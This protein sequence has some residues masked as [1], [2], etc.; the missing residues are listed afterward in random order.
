MTV[1]LDFAVLDELTTVEARAFY[2]ITDKLRSCGVTKKFRYPQIVVVGR[3]SDGKSSVLEAISHMR[4]PV[5]GDLCTRFTTDLVLQRRRETCVDVDI[6]FADSSK[7]SQHFKRTGFCPDDLP[8]IIEEAQKFMG[9]S[10]TDETFSNDLL[11]LKIDHPDTCPLRLVDVPGIDTVDQSSRSKEILDHLHLAEFYM[12]ME[13]SILLVIISASSDIA[14]HAALRKARE[15]DPRGERTM[16]IITKPDVAQEFIDERRYTQLAKSQESEQ[17]LKLG[18]H[19]LRNRAG[20]GEDGL[21]GRDAIEARFFQEDAWSCISPNDCGIA[22]LRQKLSKALWAGV[23]NNLQSV[24]DSIQGR[25]RDTQ[26]ELQTLGRPRSTIEDMRSFLLNVAGEFQRLA[27]D[28][29]RRT[30]SD[31]FFGT[32]DP[33][34][35]HKLRAQLSNFNSAFDHVLIGKENKEP[36]TEFLAG[37]LERYPYD[38]PEPIEAADLK[39]WLKEQDA[40]NQ[41]F[42]GCLNKEFIIHLFQKKAARWED[43]AALHIRQ[44]TLVT[45][46]F[47]DR[48][49]QHTIAN[50]TTLELILRNCVDPFFVQKEKLLAEKLDELLRPYTRGYAMPLDSDFRRAMSRGAQPNP[51]MADGGELGTSKVIDTVGWY[52][53]MSRRTFADNVMNLALEGCLIYDIPE[54]LTPMTVHSM[55]QERL[56]ELAS[57]SDDVKSRRQKLQEDVKILQEGLKLC[58]QYRPRGITTI[59]SALP[60]PRPGPELLEPQ[61]AIEVVPKNEQ[62]VPSNSQ[63]LLSTAKKTPSASLAPTSITA[64]A[65][66]GATKSSG[67][68]ARALLTPVPTP[69]ALPSTTS[70]PPAAANSSTLFVKSIN[71]PTV[72]PSALAPGSLFGGPSSETSSPWEAQSN[73]SHLN[74]VVSSSSTGTGLFGSFHSRNPS[75][76]SSFSFLAKK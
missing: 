46:A 36:A 47:V 31:P 25:L 3:S 19:I 15:Y 2:A 39:E 29:I 67:V 14:D 56:I 74:S 50:S 61:L 40:S 27:R 72:I 21:E 64:A 35:E 58:R 70:V 43:V 52:Y 9:V 30:Y 17:K 57:E 7:P 38:L 18:W 23:K 28:G 11:R 66:S 60:R 73:S 26:Q 59:P 5:K 32:L 13:N 53:E 33:G 65:V 42:P 71:S 41:G 12:Q 44:V 24:I 63:S 49:F 51:R 22:S 62:A 37:F 1:S 34:G 20:D 6:Q 68:F 69:E 4:F 10:A 75:P 8:S 16:C 48:L 45:K 55:S 76:Q 54:L